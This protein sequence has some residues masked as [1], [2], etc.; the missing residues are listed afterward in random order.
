MLDHLKGD[1]KEHQNACGVF[2][3]IDLFARNRK[4]AQAYKNIV[5]SPHGATFLALSI[6]RGTDVEIPICGSCKKQRKQ[7]CV[8]SY[9]T[10][11]NKNTQ[12][13]AEFGEFNGTFHSWA[14]SWGFRKFEHAALHDDEA[15]AFETIFRSSA[16]DEAMTAFERA[17]CV[18][19]GFLSLDAARDLFARCSRLSK[20]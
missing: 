13:F 5:P 9:P 10:M 2:E 3:Q 4:H 14:R 8:R 1:K 19:K 11:V 18:S 16:V 15:A 17:R 7:I 6:L 12:I 20:A